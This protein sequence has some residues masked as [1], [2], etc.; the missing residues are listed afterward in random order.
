MHVQRKKYFK[1]KQMY[2]YR[3]N[4]IN[5]LI[6]TELTYNQD[7]KLLTDVIRPMMKK[8]VAD[9]NMKAIFSNIDAIS[10]LS[11]M[12][13]HSLKENS[14]TNNFN[15]FQNLG[16][17]ICEYIPFFKIYF[18]YSCNFQSAIKS[19]L[20]MKE[21]HPREFMEIEN[22]KELKKLTIDAILIKPIQRL[23][24]YVLLLKEIIKN[25]VQNDV[26]FPN[27]KKALDQFSFVNNDMNEKLD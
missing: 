6:S 21:K 24:K 1:L 19:Y 15:F 8:F 7:L 16:Q 5:E 13:Y 11:D 14:L 3:K 25:S 12:F 26:D 23:T 18:D 9:I 10:K 27:L 22:I 4:V 2:S 20:S 17:C